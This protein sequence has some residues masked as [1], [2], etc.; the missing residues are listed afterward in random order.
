M[1]SYDVTRQRVFY[2]GSD[3]R[4]L[5][6]SCRAMIII[7]GFP[8]WLVACQVFKVRLQT[9]LV[10]YMYYATPWLCVT[11]GLLSSQRPSISWASDNNLPCANPFERKNERTWYSPQTT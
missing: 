9:E 5:P 8:S 4:L 11:S 1:M 10:L 2:R 6:H 3:N 7:V